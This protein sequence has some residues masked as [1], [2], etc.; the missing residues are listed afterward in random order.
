MVQNCKTCGLEFRARRIDV[1]RGH[2]KFCSAKCFGISIRG[3][4]SNTP[5]AKCAFCEIDFKRGTH[6]SKSGL[7][8]CCRSHKDSAQRIGGI[9]EIMPSH[10]GTSAGAYDYRDRAIKHYGNSCQR[11]GFQDSRAIV[12]HHKDHNRS[13]NS[14]DNLAVLCCNCH[15]IQHSE[16]RESGKFKE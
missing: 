8:F 1:G 11:C 6:I 5:N 13:N 4:K 15:Y 10:Y 9:R 3:P 2:S 12:V 7:Y 14:I 16:D